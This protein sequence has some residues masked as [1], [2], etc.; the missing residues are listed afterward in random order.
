MR[1]ELVPAKDAAAYWV[2]HVLRHGTQHLQF[3]VK[4][5]PFYKVYLLD[6]WLF[7][8]AIFTIPPI[9]LFKIIKFCMRRK[10]S[11]KKGKTE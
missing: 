6:I 10:S 3:K 8:I 9:V 2:E 4:D 5:M 1:D 11:N 7:L